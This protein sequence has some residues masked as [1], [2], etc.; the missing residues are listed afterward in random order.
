M[1]KEKSCGAVTYKLENNTI[2]Y[3]IEFMALGH[4]SLPKGH[5]ENN[6]TEVE[7]VLREI[8]EETNLD[9]KVDTNFR[10]TITYSPKE[11]VIKDVVFFVAEAISENLINQ[12]CEVSSLK[13][14]SFNEAIEILTYQSDKDVLTNANEYLLK[15]EK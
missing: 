1:I 4:I 5:V 15:N 7:T 3:L 10:Y 8:K 9:V 6:E 13:W 12:E 11:N 2:L 14:M